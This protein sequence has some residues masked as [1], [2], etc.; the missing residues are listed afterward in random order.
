MKKFLNKKSA[1]ENPTIYGIDKIIHN[2]NRTSNNI[3]SSEMIGKKI[4]EV[5]KEKEK[6]MELAK[7]MVKEKKKIWDFEHTRNLAEVIM[8]YYTSRKVC[9]MYLV[10]VVDQV[11]KTNKSFIK[12]RNDIL[13]GIES[14]CK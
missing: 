7:T 6:A 11:I 1:S 12:D 14:L 10:S 9:N 5:I 8:F 4:L 3:S 2:C 13:E